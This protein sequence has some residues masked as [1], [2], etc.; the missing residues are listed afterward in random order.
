MRKYAQTDSTHSTTSAWPRLLRIRPHTLLLVVGVWLALA[1][2]AFIMVDILGWIDPGLERPVWRLLFNDRPVEWTQWLILAFA[3]TASGYLAG[4]LN[5]SEDYTGAAR[6]FFLL[7]IGFSLMLIEDAGDIRHTLNS[8]AELV[9]GEELAGIRTQFFV[10]APYFL[11]L[12]AVPIYALVRYGRYVWHFVSVRRH[13]LAGFVLYGLA[14]GGSA[15]SN[16]GHS[17]VVL[18]Y[19]FDT[20]LLGGRL[21]VL[22]GRSQEFTHFIFFD[23]AVEET[24]ELLGLTM[25]AA[26][27]LAYCDNLRRSSTHANKGESR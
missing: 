13:L 25:L 7:S 24:V 21:G 16:L 12:A 9:L 19:L 8:D 18:G 11:A 3:I 2:G 22:P 10:E 17:Y 1:W 4:S 6:F 26:A 15:L 5:Q 14:A 27:V 20:F 23:S